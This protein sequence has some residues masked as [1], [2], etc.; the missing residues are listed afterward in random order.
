MQCELSISRRSVVQCIRRMQPD[1]ERCVHESGIGVGFSVVP[2]HTLSVD[3]SA[4][5]ARRSGQ[6]REECQPMGEAQ[7][8]FH[9]SP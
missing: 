7:T 1:G 2:V 3:P 9:Q 5:Y 6:S 4:L 8:F